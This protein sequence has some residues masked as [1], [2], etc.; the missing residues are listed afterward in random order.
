MAY[1][2]YTG[3]STHTQ[4]M[5]QDLQRGEGIH[6]A[7]FFIAEILDNWDCKMGKMVLWYPQRSS[8]LWDT[9]FSGW[10]IGCWRSKLRG[11]FLSFSLQLILI[12][13]SE[14]LWIFKKQ[15]FEQHWFPVPSR[16]PEYSVWLWATPR[17]VHTYSHSCKWFPQFL[18]LFWVFTE[19]IAVRESHSILPD[20]C[21]C[22][23]G[24]LSCQV[25]QYVG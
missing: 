20:W 17:S 14:T 11:K 6:R 19:L 12:L 23:E 4:K 24:Q 13:Y 3:L 22:T 10:H 7:P 15:V 9:D 18:W 25:L 5:R 1:T 2:P 8:F 16:Q 21:L